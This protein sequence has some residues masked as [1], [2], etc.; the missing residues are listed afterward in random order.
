MTSLFQVQIKDGKKKSAPVQLEEKRARSFVLSAVQRLIDA[1]DKRV[2][3]FKASTGIGKSTMLLHELFLNNPQRLVICSQVT[4]INAMSIAQYV[5][6]LNGMELG[7][8]VGYTTSQGRVDIAGPGIVYQTI[9]TT[10]SAFLAPMLFDNKG[11]PN[12]ILVIDE[13]HTNQIQMQEQ[14]AYV[15]SIV[16]NVPDALKPFIIIQSAS[17]DENAFAEYFDTDFI[18]DLQGSRQP[19]TE[20]T[21]SS[22]GDLSAARSIGQ[23]TAE[24]VRR[25]LNYKEV[26]VLA[27]AVAETRVDPAGSI[28][29]FVPS[30][31]MITR[32]EQ[33]LRI[34]NCPL[35]I[36]C[37]SGASIE[38]D[39]R[40]KDQALSREQK[41][42]IAT[43]V[44]ET[45]F[46]IDGLSFVID[47]LK[48]MTVYYNPVTKARTFRSIAI[49]SSMH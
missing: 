49:D 24:C 40:L 17:I 32:I 37:L 33:D 36:L 25:I 39:P 1:G 35:P 31:S 2:I 38:K 22:F 16:K 29:V 8:N 15:H 3:V 27:N 18:V 13:A 4:I 6:T 19:V 43:N 10:T 26:P 20:L 11:F 7:V 14:L 41:V 23:A 46:T 21:L 34:D 48:C 30:Q 5:G 44:I 9:K 47:T 45:G 42:I 12:A 28:L